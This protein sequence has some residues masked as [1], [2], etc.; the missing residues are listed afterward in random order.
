MRS[1]ALLL[2][3][4][5]FLLTRPVLAQD[6]SAEVAHD[7]SEAELAE[8]QHSFEL[9]TAAYEGGDY[10][11]AA[12]EFRVAYEITRHP[13]LLFNV[14]LAE[15]RA[16]RPSEAADALTSYLATASVAAEERVLLERRLERLRARAAS[17]E[18]TPPV[19]ELDDSALLASPIEAAPPATAVPVPAAESAGSP[20][21]AGIALLVTAGVLLV[22]F[23]V[24]APLSEVEDQRLATSCGRER[25]RTCTDTTALT[26]LNVASDVSWIGAAALGTAGLILLFALPWEGAT[27]GDVAVLPWASPDGAGLLVGGSF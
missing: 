17:R 4:G 6:A 13:E 11:T 8:A 18:T 9:A 20:P 12:E 14:Y 7:A 22:S 16:G 26:A 24:L 21:T 10:E 2:A 25:G 5:S 23:A 3:C 27:R 15:E 19:E 1:L